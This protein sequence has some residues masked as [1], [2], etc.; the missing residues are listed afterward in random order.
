MK[1]SRSAEEYRILCTTYLRV[2]L[3]I[4]VPD[5]EV[6]TMNRPLFLHLVGFL[7]DKIPFNFVLDVSYSANPSNMGLHLFDFCP[8]KFPVDSRCIR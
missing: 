1:I 5:F 2:Y 4:A 8:L 6:E 3:G 7:C